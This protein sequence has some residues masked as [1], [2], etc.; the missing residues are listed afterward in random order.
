MLYRTLLD[1]SPLQLQAGDYCDSGKVLAARRASD[2]EC[3]MAERNLQPIPRF[4]FT[5]EIDGK[6]S[7]RFDTKL[8]T[9]LTIWRP[10]AGTE[11]RL[12]PR[13]AVS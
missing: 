1:R 2:K 8:P 10:R 4:V 3:R 12:A 6:K 5:L 13:K 11:I 7:D 9:S